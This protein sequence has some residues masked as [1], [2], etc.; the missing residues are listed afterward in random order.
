MTLLF[1]DTV[2]KELQKTFAK[3]TNSFQ[4][5]TSALTTTL[6]GARENRKIIWDT[7]A[8]GQTAQGNTQKHKF[9][10]LKKHTQLYIYY[11]YFRQVIPIQ[12]FV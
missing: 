6:L 3:L 9:Y 11:T 1:L 2:T 4:I 8:N 5:S 10:Q 12:S 7:L